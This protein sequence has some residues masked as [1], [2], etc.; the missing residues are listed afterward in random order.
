[1]SRRSIAGKRPYRDHYNGIGHYNDDEAYEQDMDVWKGKRKAVNNFFKALRSPPTSSAPRSASTS[2]AS[3]AAPTFS[4]PTLSAPTSS[5]PRTAPDRPLASTSSSPARPPTRHK[6]SEDKDIIKSSESQK[7]EKTLAD[8]KERQIILQKRNDTIQQSI[9]KIGKKV[10]LHRAENITESDEDD[11]DSDVTFIKNIAHQAEHGRESDEDSDDL[12]SASWPPKIIS[13]RDVQRNMVETSTESDGDDLDFSLDEEDNIPDFDETVK[14]VPQVGKKSS[15][16]TLSDLEKMLNAE[17]LKNQRLQTELDQVQRDRSTKNDSYLSQQKSLIDLKEKNSMLQEKLDKTQEEI[18]AQTEVIVEKMEI[19]DNLQ[20]NSTERSYLAICRENVDL[21]RSN[22]ELEANNAVLSPAAKEIRKIRN[23][24]IAKIQ[25]GSRETDE[26]EHENMLKLDILSLFQKYEK[27]VALQDKKLTQKDERT[28][29]KV[30]Q[31]NLDFRAINEQLKV[32]NAE[33]EKLKAKIVRF[34]AKIKEHKNKACTE[35]L[36][37]QK[38]SE[39]QEAIGTNRNEPDKIKALEDKLKD[40]NETLLNCKTKLDLQK[41][42]SRMYQKQ[43]QQMMDILKIPQ[44]DRSFAKVLNAVTAFQEAKAG[45]FTNTEE[46]NEV[47]LYENAE[48][49]LQD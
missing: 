21:K 45:I 17:R 31:A 37:L 27:S 49:I 20:Q 18:S 8:L 24:L 35:S 40:A 10:I 19:I 12:D 6:K 48:R 32:K 9:E 25:L 34:K 46:Q 26:N 3:R 29:K 42:M 1:M 22:K 28:E 2:S 4:V 15:T 30:S 14:K 5:A 47:D 23:S 11:S 36:T 38:L 41:E 39:L 7:T 44:E 33:V 13:D 43:Q 16:K